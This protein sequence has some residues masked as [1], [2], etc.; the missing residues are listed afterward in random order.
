MDGQKYR[1]RRIFQEKYEFSASR[2]A[3]VLIH[4]RFC[5]VIK[6]TM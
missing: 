1:V 6:V 2:Q 4:L 5:L 3:G